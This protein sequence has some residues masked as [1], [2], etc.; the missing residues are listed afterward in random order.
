MAF[1]DAELSNFEKQSICLGNM[2][3]ILPDNTEKAVELA[4]KFLDGGKVSEKSEVGGQPERFFSF[5]KDA[6]FI[7]SSF[8]QKFNIDLEAENNLHWWKFIAMFFDLGD[9]SFGYISNLRKTI[10]TGHGTD[11]DFRRAR[12]LGDIFELEA[13]DPRTPEQIEMDEIFDNA[14]K[15]GA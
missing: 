2:Y 10:Q 13:V 1:E 12:E 4:V 11:D 7:Y 14:L 6:K 8:K 15:G 5:D 3:P 9:T